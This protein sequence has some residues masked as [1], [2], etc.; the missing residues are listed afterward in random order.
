M[1]NKIV[2]AILFLMPIFVF[3]QNNR[4]SI[5]A[6]FVNPRPVIRFQNEG[7]VNAYH[8]PKDVGFAIG[9]E[10]NWKQTAR[11]RRYQTVMLGYSHINYIENVLS[12]ETAIGWDW[13]IFKGLHAGFSTGVGFH[14][15]KNADVQY[16]YEGDEWVPT[17]ENKIATNRFAVNLQAQ[18]GYR[19]AK[20]WDVFV[21]AGIVGF[22]P[23]IKLEEG[24]FPF[25]A[26]YQPRLGVRFQL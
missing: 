2:L 11:F 1:K 17:N 12:L 4:W 20:K 3:S 9:V 18:I 6:D 14:R 7:V 24:T 22:T 23:L 16:K 19:F 10:R 25:F 5:R 13:R 15:A 21:G 8:N 26:N